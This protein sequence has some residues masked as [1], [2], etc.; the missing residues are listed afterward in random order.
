MNTLIGSG[1][2]T[3]PMSVLIPVAAAA[4]PGLVAVALLISVR[5]H[6]RTALSPRAARLVVAAW[7]LGALA[8]LAGPAVTLYS[9]WA[10]VG[11]VDAPAPGLDGFGAARWLLTV[12]GVGF[13]IGVVVY[14]ADR[15][16]VLTS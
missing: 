13:L 6:L 11:R 2:G 14:A 8:L 15:R 1:D 5:P 4:T 3:D 10:T 7:G 12:G 16:D 9:Y